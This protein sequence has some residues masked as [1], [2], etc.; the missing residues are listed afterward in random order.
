M[1]EVKTPAK[2]EPRRI[3]RLLSTDIDG[4]LPVERALRRIKGVSFMLSHAACVSIGVDPKKKL[5]MLAEAEIKSID[6]YFKNL[7]VGKTNLPAWI[8]NRR[9]DVET[10]ENFHL[11][12]SSLDFRKREDINTLKRMRAYRGVRHELGLP[13]RGQRT[14]SSFRKNKTVGVSKKKAMAARKPAPKAKEEK[15]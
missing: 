1:E 7:A 14:R 15:K 10:G 12:G 4:R 6:E 13:V 9:N 11:I 8:I 3:V 5:G 2:T